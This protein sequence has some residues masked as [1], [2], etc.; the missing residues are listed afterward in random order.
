MYRFLYLFHSLSTIK[1]LV[2]VLYFDHAVTTIT[3]MNMLVFSPYK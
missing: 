3:T 2:V 1:M